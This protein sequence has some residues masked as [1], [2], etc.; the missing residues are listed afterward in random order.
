MTIWSDNAAAMRSLA[1]TLRKLANDM[2][3]SPTNRAEYNRLMTDAK[4]YDERASEHQERH[5]EAIAE[6]DEPNGD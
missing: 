6:D 4:W 2:V 3:D 5:D 1:A